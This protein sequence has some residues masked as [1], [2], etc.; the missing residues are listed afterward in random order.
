[1]RRGGL[2]VLASFLI[3]LSGPG[4]ALAQAVLPDEP[5]ASP[6]AL[7]DQAPAQDTPLAPPRQAGAPLPYAP[8]PRPEAMEPAA[9]V[10][11]PPVN[12]LEVPPL[13]RAALAPP[14]GAAAGADEPTSDMMKAA[15]MPAGPVNPD[16][17]L[18]KSDEA[19]LLP[20]PV[21]VSTISPSALARTG[22]LT[23]QEAGFPA[24]LWTSTS[25]AEMLKALESAAP[26][27]GS[28]VSYRTLR[29]LALAITDMPDVSERG[30][31]TLLGARL[32]LLSRLGDLEGL[33]AL[34]AR[35]P[36]DLAPLDI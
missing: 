26:A 16:G 20:Q 23:D 24:G 12:L 32:D 9:A 4:N 3:G 27:A 7:P 11:P 30:A 5:E 33:H 34:A 22:T 6:L 31:W 19:P 35:L 1:M 2:V 17:V 25:Y 18:E 15:P 13:P 28:P 21:S 14:D 36:D 8:A 29:R 10:M